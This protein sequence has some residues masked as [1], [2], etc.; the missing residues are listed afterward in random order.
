MQAA[1]LVLGSDVSTLTA[2]CAAEGF[3]LVSSAHTFT[4]TYADQNNTGNPPLGTAAPAMQYSTSLFLF[5]V[6][7]AQNCPWAAG[8]TV[9][10]VSGTDGDS[11]SV[12]PRRPSTS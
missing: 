1:L 7:S 2:P 3:D 12:I 9:G 8:A 5:K 4:F 10:Y 11:I 6:E